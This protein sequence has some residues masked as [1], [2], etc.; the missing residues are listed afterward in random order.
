MTERK[1]LVA[2]VIERGDIVKLLYLAEGPSLC[3]CMGPRNGEP[4]CRCRMNSKE[5]RDAISYF[6]LKRGKIIRLRKR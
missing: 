6:A 4:L 2:A 1:K 5:V 3:S